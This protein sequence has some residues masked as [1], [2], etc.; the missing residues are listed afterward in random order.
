[1]TDAL[2]WAWN[3]TQSFLYL[4]FPIY[5]PT[6]FFPRLPC[7]AFPIFHYSGLWPVSQ[8]IHHWP[9]I[10]IYS[11][12]RLLSFHLMLMTRCTSPKLCLLE[13]FLL[14]NIFQ[15]YSGSGALMQ[16]LSIFSL[17]PCLD[18][19]KQ[20]IHKLSSASPLFYKMV[21]KIPM[22]PEVWLEVDVLV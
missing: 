6:S 13:R 21:I 4:S 10:C 8:T 11:Y 17:H 7:L 18:I 20:P 19:W 2:W 1:M 14:K 5:L 9:W 16:L 15:G 3:A 22:Q 12:N